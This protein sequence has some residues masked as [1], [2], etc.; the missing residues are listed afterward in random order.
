MDFVV[1]LP[2]TPRGNDSIWVIVDHLTKVAHFVPVKTQHRTE[3]LAELYV[4]HILTVDRLWTK[5][6]RQVLAKFSQ[7][8][9]HHS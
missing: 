1:D 3:R 9:G 8:Y 4:E 2:W 7:A 6:C 5:V